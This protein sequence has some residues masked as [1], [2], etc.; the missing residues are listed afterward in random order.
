MRSKPAKTLREAAYFAG[1]VGPL[2]T[3]VLNWWVVLVLALMALVHTLVAFIG[4]LVVAASWGAARI[5]CEW[6]AKKYRQWVIAR[7]VNN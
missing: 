7:A 1:I 6:I 4:Y 5:A 2:W 3:V